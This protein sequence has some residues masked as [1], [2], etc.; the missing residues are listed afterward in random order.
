MKL[1]IVLVSAL[2]LTACEQS[3][4]YESDGYA[5]GAW[6]SAFAAMG[7]AQPVSGLT[8]RIAA[9]PKFAGESHVSQYDTSP[10][11]SPGR[12]LYLQAVSKFYYEGAVEDGVVVLTDNATVANLTVRGCTA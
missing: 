2:V 9:H 3:F 10:D 11:Q 8:E 5:E 7:C 12:A 4:Y 6:A 1:R